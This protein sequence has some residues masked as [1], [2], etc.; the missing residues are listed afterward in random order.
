MENKK[1]ITINIKKQKRIRRIKRS[2]SA[3][4]AGGII[5]GVMLYVPINIKTKNLIENEAV[6]SERFKKDMK[7][8]ETFN[9][10]REESVSIYA[11]DEVSMEIENKINDVLKELKN[12]VTDKF[13]E[14]VD[15]LNV[16]LSTIS[17]DNNTE[18]EGMF[19]K[20]NEDK[21][22]GFTSDEV[23]K[24]NKLLD[25]YHSV[26][27]NQNYIDARSLLEEINNYINEV[28]KSVES[29]TT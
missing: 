21:L 23:A 10:L 2:I 11:S 4:V 29:R 20:L 5:I 16:L 26:I 6:A 15:N 27:Q 19:N 7:V 14:L 24:V 18:L 1:N 22:T 12:G 17:A 9:R 8:L 25:E 13:K 28:K 3:M